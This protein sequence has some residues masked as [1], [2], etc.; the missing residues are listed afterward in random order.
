[1]LSLP[2]SKTVSSTE[3]F[4]L[5]MMLHSEVQRKAQEQIDKVIGHDRLPQFSDKKDLPY[6]DCI[7]WEVLRWKPI[8]PLS[9]AHY[10]V[11]EDIYEGYLIP[12]GTTVFPNVWSVFLYLHC[13]CLV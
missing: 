5:A 4:L 7:L 9:I 3:S 11:K 12:K 10:T 6:I 1:M 8:V 13:H 2:G